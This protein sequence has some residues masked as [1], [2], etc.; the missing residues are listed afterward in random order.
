MRKNVVGLLHIIQELTQNRSKM[1]P[2]NCNLEENMGA[3]LHDLRLGS[4]FLA[5]S[6]KAQTRRKNRLT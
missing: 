6:P 5:M 2:K 1:S 4:G 3:N